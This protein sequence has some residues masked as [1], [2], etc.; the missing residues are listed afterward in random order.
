LVCPT[1]GSAAR[2][3]TA[4]G[5][6]PTVNSRS[7]NEAP[8]PLLPKDAH[9]ALQ[10]TASAHAPAI[11]HEGNLSALVIGHHDPNSGRPH[12]Q[13]G[14]RRCVVVQDEVILQSLKPCVQFLIRARRAAEF[15][16]HVHAHLCQGEAKQEGNQR[17][18]EQIGLGEGNVH[19]QSEHDKRAQAGPTANMR[20]A[21]DKFFVF[22]DFHIDS[23]RP[24]RNE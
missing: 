18:D 21:F 11:L 13:M 5:A 6:P 9:V 22:D 10:K 7:P 3:S 24:E 15:I 23:Y 20:I 16:S 2:C 1:R 19:A 4:T 12:Q 17:V 14:N 8:Q